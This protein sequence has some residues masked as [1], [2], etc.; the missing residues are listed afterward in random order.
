MANRVFFSFHY[1]D[2][3]NFR[4]NVVRNHWLTKPDR[5]AAGFYDASIW[6]SAKKQGDMALKRLINGGLDNT[7]NTCV[8]IGSDTYARPWVRYEILKSFKRGNHLFGVH[9]N[10]IKGKDGLT[11]LPGPNPFAYVGVTFSQSGETA[12]LW[13]LVGGNWVEYGKVDEGAS[14]RFQVSQEYRGNGYNLGK[15]YS[16]YDWTANDGF[17]NFSNWLK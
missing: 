11:K 3:I 5:E 17:N 14:Y 7:S 15:W 12:T 16:V 10:S 4:A 1:Q 9:I 2:V 6:E 13:E 8:L